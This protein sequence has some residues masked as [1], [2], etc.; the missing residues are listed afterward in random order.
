MPL[1]THYHLGMPL[2]FECLSKTALIIFITVI[3][4]L[5][6]AIT[7]SSAR[8]SLFKLASPK[9]YEKSKASE[10]YSEKTYF[11]NKIL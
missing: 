8:S 9:L 4:E 5:L 11:F 1:H 6:T 7:R 10:D 2:I 3:T